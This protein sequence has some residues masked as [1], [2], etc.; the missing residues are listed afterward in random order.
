[1]SQ[2]WLR[3]AFAVALVALAATMTVGAAS[4]KPS[5]GA[6]PDVKA[7]SRSSRGK[8]PRLAFRLLV[9]YTDPTDNGATYRSRWS[10]TIRRPVTR[11]RAAR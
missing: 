3:T 6:K 10:A 2:R 8:P 9:P 11:A 4:A 7:V 5:P 1:M